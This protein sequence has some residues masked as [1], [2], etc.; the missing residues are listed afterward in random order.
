MLGAWSVAASSRARRRAGAASLA[1]VLSAAEK[2]GA[3]GQWASRAAEAA[4]EGDNAAAALEH[5]CNRRLRV[6]LQAWSAATRDARALR[7]GAELLLR[8]R[9][10][11][12]AAAGLRLWRRQ[13]AKV[14]E[15]ALR[16]LRIKVGLAFGLC[17]VCCLFA[18]LWQM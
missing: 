4:L 13:A 18:F 11:S 17:V 7:R 15:A 16:K 5:C 12:A 3:F 8:G 1:S 14:R 2:R 9:R 6:H 10:V